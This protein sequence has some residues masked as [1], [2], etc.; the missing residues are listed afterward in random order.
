MHKMQQ[1]G[2]KPARALRAVHQ[3]MRYRQV[4]GMEFDCGKGGPGSGGGDS[5]APYYCEA[6]FIFHVRRAQVIPLRRA[7]HRPGG[8]HGWCR[9]WC[10]RLLLLADAPGLAL[11]CGGLG[12]RPSVLA[13]ADRRRHDL[14]WAE[15][16]VQPACRRGGG[17]RSRAAAWGARS[18]HLPA[19]LPL[20]GGYVGHFAGACLGC[21][22][23]WRTGCGP[24]PCARGL[25]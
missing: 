6:V 12:C 17:P 10:R 18:P 25:H 20:R 15:E 2:N 16:R 9:R 1:K 14:G 13:L 19:L 24:P 3:L 11:L 22:C 23:S 4:C 5:A 8:C 7:T 21:S